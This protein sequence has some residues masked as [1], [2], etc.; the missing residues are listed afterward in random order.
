MMD[1]AT[2]N[3]F[4]KNQEILVTTAKGKFYGKFNKLTFNESR[5][6]ISDVKGENGKSCGAFKYF[7]KKDVISVSIV[8]EELKRNEAEEG[9]SNI[10]TQPLA[11]QLAPKQ[12][13]NVTQSI[14]NFTY[15]QQADSKYFE[16]IEDISK[17]F[18][19][20]IFGDCCRGR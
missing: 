17:Q 20:G 4:E 1:F 3:K 5:L 14:N 10:E 2:L 18:V 6:D 8:G 19:I 15:I 12:L 9:S 13:Q 16:A 7:F 11:S